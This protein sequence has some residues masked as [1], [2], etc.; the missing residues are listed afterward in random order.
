MRTLGRAL[1]LTAVLVGLGL[2]APSGLA[3]Q[4]RYIGLAGGA[5]L[6]DFSDD[7]GDYSTDSRWGAN[8]GLVMGVRTKDRMSLSVEPAWSQMGGADGPIDYLEV[9]VLIGGMARSGSA[10]RFGGYSG[11]IPAFKLSCG[12]EQPS[13]SCD[14]LKGSAWFLP[15][16]ARFYRQ[17]GAGK[18]IGL[19]VRYAIPLGSSFESVSVNQRAWSFRLVFVKGEL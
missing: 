11:I 9:P 14:D 13:G 8:I 15:L 3:A 17:A 6:S 19:D 7:F 2:A 1:G 12:I 18:W 16:G 10:T 4:S 5:N